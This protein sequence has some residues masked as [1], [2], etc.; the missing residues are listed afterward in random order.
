MPLPPESQPE[1]SSAVPSAGRWIL[2]DCS[3][4]TSKAT[5]EGRGLLSGPVPPE[6]ESVDS[7]FLHRSGQEP[8]PDQPMTN[9]VLPIEPHT[10][11]G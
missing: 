10:G 11:S 6:L 2:R 8:V 9:H 3:G 5:L 1:R 4:G 7:C